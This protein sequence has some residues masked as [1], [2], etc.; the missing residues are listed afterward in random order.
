MGHEGRVCDVVAPVLVEEV[1]Q[2]HAPPAPQQR[3]MCQ[4]RGGACVRAGG[5][6]VSAHAP[7]ACVCACVRVCV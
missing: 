5:V 6:H 2:R 4:G 3:S 7:P 1:P